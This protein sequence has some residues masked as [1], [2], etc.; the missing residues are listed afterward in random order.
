MKQEMLD[1]TASDYVKQIETN[2]EERIKEL[3]AK[4][5]ERIKELEY[6]YLEMKEKYDLLIYKRFVRSAEQLMANEKQ[7]LLFIEET[8]KT[9]GTVGKQI[10]QEEVKSY[11]RKKSG[12]KPIDP[13]LHREER[14]L[15]IPD[16][17][18]TCVCGAELTRIGEGSF[19]LKSA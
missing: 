1:A 11:R 14:I 6:Q 17:E 3:Q 2:Y 4:F 19:G 7:Q 5:E 8:D 13:K 9:T 18:K 16:S 12:R 15:D 10:E